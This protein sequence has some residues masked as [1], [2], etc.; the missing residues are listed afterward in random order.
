MILRQILRSLRTLV[1]SGPLAPQGSPASTPNPDASTKLNLVMVTQA[2]L[3]I[4]K[5]AP[6][7]DLSDS[8][9][10]QF[11]GEVSDHLE[12][13]ITLAF[14][15]VECGHL[16]PSLVD[17][18]DALE[19]SDVILTLQTVVQTLRISGH[20][21]HINLAWSKQLE[22]LYLKTEQKR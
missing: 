2:L 13:V 21:S 11:T 7:I 17:R 6:L 4:Y 19:W 9:T 22:D 14:R 20:I 15:M 5:H 12:E 1:R 18:N 8:Y 3:Q 16:S 10:L